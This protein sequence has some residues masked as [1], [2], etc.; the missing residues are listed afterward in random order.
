[1]KNYYL[2]QAAKERSQ[3]FGFAMG[4]LFGTFGVRHAKAGFIDF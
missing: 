4:S 2:T 1:L 3:A